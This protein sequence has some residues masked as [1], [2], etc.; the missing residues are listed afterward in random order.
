M[1]HRKSCATTVGTM[2]GNALAVEYEV[3][4]VAAEAFLP[5]GL[6]LESNRNENI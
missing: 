6:S 1:V 3:D 5:D 4:S 2:F